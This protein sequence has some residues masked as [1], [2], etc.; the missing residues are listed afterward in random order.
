MAK[1]N[2]REKQEIRHLNLIQRLQKERA[3]ITTPYA[4]KICAK[5]PKE[6]H[7]QKLIDLDKD[8]IVSHPKYRELTQQ[9][10]KLYLELSPTTKQILQ[11][12]YPQL[13]PVHL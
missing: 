8:L 12:N 2:P 3:T 11:E 9:I 6:T 5:R 7:K 13:C 4:H 10:Q 1:F